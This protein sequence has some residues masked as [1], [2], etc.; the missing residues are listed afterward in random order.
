[1]EKKGI[2]RIFLD[3]LDFEV[4]AD[5]AEDEALQVLDQVVEHSQAFWVSAGHV[6]RQDEVRGAS[7]ISSALGHYNRRLLQPGPGTKVSNSSL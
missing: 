1:M 6:D 3:G 5:E 4:Q 7:V 2:V